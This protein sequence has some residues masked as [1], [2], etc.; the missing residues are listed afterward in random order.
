[1]L[2]QQQKHRQQ[3]EKKICCCCCCY[4]WWNFSATKKLHG[5]RIH[6]KQPGKLFALT[7][8]QQQQQEQF[9]S[10]STKFFD[11][12]YVLWYFE[13]VTFSTILLLL[14]VHFHMAYAF[15]VVILLPDDGIGIRHPELI[16]CAVALADD[17]H[18]SEWHRRKIRKSSIDYVQTFFVATLSKWGSNVWLSLIENF[19]G[20]F[21]IKSS[22]ACNALEFGD[23]TP[24]DLWKTSTTDWICYLCQQWLLMLQ[25]LLLLQ[26]PGR[27]AR[28][29][30][31]LRVATVQYTF[32][33]SSFSM[34]DGCVDTTWA[35]RGLIY[36]LIGSAKKN[37]SRDMGNWRLGETTWVTQFHYNDDG[38]PCQCRD[39]DIASQLLLLCCPP[40]TPEP[41]SSEEYD[42]GLTSRFS[43]L[44]L[45]SVSE[46][47]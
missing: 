14:F 5:Q 11:I 44:D 24:I 22:L 12:K 7:S 47:C 26:L 33:T 9:Q 6:R 3:K 23:G 13:N 15:V 21:H 8:E 32:S 4:C 27:S 40:R 17:T 18:A 35:I 25:R 16:A 43:A 2:Q 37:W 19:S 42:E 41:A 20:E 45:A 46:L 38:M 29:E 30:R 28:F 10:L 1:M 31:W 34:L 36:T 39:T